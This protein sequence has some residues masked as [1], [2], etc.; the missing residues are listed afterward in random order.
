MI[1]NS[2]LL[3]PQES[4][5]I[6]GAAMKV[7]EILGGGFTEKVYQDALAVE[8]GEQGI[9]FQREQEIH[10]HY[11][12]VTLPSTFVPDFICYNCIIVE[13]KAVRELED[14]HRSQA[15]N[16]AKVA[17]MQLALLVNFGT[18]RLEYERFPVFK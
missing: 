16:Y 3:F 5:A 8:F 18:D 10:A 2:K 4:Y 11:K 14:I 17:N 6:V 9:P 7:H 12:G 1:H 15:F 13:L